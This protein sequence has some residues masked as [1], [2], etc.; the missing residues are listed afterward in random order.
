MPLKERWMHVKSIEDQ[1]ADV[2]VECI[3]VDGVSLP[4]GATE[5]PT[6]RGE[7]DVSFLKLLIKYADKREKDSPRFLNCW[8][9]VQKWVVKNSDGVRGMKKDA[10]RIDF[11]DSHGSETTARL[12]R[13]APTMHR[14][15]PRALKGRQTRDQRN[16]RCLDMETRMLKR[17][18]R[19]ITRTFT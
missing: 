14:E 12:E 19:Q 17:R 1:S 2:D 18:A 11:S 3:L 5:D 9:Q 8:D 13:R 10:G 15:R 16:R 4:T 7:W 6:Y